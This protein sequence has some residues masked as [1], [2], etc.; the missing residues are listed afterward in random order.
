M[1]RALSLGVA[2]AAIAG[3]AGTERWTEVGVLAPVVYEG[4]LPCADCEGIQTALLL[5]PDGVYF[6][7]SEYLGEPAG[8]NGFMDY[9]R[10]RERGGIIALEGMSGTPRFFSVESA[11]RVRLLD[12]EGQPIE[13]ALNYHLDRMG[14]RTFFRDAFLARGMFTYYADSAHLRL[15]GAGLRLPVAMEGAYLELERAY[16]DIPKNPAAE[17]LAEVRARIDWRPR[18]EGEGVEPAWVIETFERLSPGSSC[19]EPLR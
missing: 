1:T 8:D 11:I 2:L 18:M 19:P 15:C 10:W 13:S 6:L 5:R 4:V 17:V 16:L 14:D 9:G 7:R 3:C 12:T